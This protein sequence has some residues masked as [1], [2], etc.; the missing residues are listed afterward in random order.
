M[1]FLDLLIDP[2]C[3][4][5]PIL[6]KIITITAS[7]YSIIKRAPI[8]AILI[9]KF[10]SK[11]SPLIIF[12]NAFITIS[13]PDNKYAIRNNIQFIFGFEYEYL[14][15]KGANTELHLADGSIELHP[16]SVRL[17]EWKNYALNLGLAFH[18]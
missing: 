14:Q 1:E 10:S 11:N 7:G 2:F 4:Y 16:S 9:K 6:Y 13:T 18:F 17:A 8:V 12:F 3:K 5:S 15:N